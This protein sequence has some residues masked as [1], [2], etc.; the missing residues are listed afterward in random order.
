MFGPHPSDP[1]SSLGG[2]ILVL[3][4]I[5]L[6]SEDAPG[7]IGV[8][9]PCSKAQHILAAGGLCTHPWYTVEQLH[10]RRNSYLAAGDAR[11][12]GSVA[13]SAC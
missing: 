5:F 13:V 2:E 9:A 8:E 1:D 7:S 3:E 12:W 11:S 10:D 6:S 4:Q